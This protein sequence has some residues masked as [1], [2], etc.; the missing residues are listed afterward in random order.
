VADSSGVFYGTTYYGGQFGQGSVYKAIPPA[1][2][3]GTWTVSTLYSF[4]KTKRTDG[5]NPQGGLVL[6]ESTRTLYGTAMIGGPNNDGVVYQLTAPTTAGAPWTQTVL[7][8]FTGGV[9]GSEPAAGLVSDAKGVLYGTTFWGGQYANGVVFK[10]VPPATKGGA[11]TEVVI[12]S[13]KG[14]SDGRTPYASLIFDASG[15]LYGTTYSGGQGGNLGCCGTVFQLIPSG[16]NGPWKEVTLHRFSG[17]EGSAPVSSLLLD[18]SGALYG[19]TSGFGKTNG[20]VF[21]LVPPA[22]AGGAWTENT[23]YTF[24]GGADGGTPMAAVIGDGTGALY[25]TTYSGGTTCNG[26][27]TVFKLIPPATQ[28]AAWT[29]QVLHDFVGGND[30]SLPLAPLLL[31]GNTF[32]G[33][34]Y[35]GGA[36]VNPAGTLFEITP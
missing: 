9:D 29:E 35:Y 8:S 28:G 13:F 5:G 24:T 7:Y 22:V 19:T 18:S 32:Y 21:Q 23:L 12:H 34:T 17:A 20:T 33:T 10:L 2:S 4:S 1:N 27:G 16:G 26:C 31:R 25:G 6:N 30:G 15:S 11:W 3:G 36:V 14:G